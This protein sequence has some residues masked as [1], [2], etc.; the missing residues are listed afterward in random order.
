MDRAPAGFRSLAPTSMQEEYSALP[1][2][3]VSDGGEK[4]PELP[5]IGRL[6]I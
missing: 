2:T 3:L 6:A 4:I 5:W 1:V